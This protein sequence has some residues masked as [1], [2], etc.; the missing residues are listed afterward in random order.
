MLWDLKKKD[1]D[2]SLMSLSCHSLSEILSEKFRVWVSF[3]LTFVAHAKDQKM[4]TRRI[5]TT[6]SSC[7]LQLKT[8]KQKPQPYFSFFIHSFHNIY[9]M[10]CASIWRKVMLKRV[11]TYAWDASKWTSLYFSRTFV[12]RGCE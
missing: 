8:N 11:I 7:V 3:C 9:W 2:I 10:L 6:K 1:S 4:E 12:E 5:T